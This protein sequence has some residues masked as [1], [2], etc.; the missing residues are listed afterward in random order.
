MPFARLVG[1]RAVLALL[2]RGVARDSLP[3]SLMFVGPEGVGKCTTAVA[4]AQLLNCEQVVGAGSDQPDACGRC[5]TC[6][7]IAAGTY[8]ELL[9]VVPG[10]NATIRIEAVRDVLERVPYRPFEGRRR[11]VIVDRA[12]T[13]QPGAQNALLKTLEEPNSSTVFVLVT[14]RP[15][16]MLDTVQSR[17]PR[18]RFGQLDANDVATV[19]MRDHRYNESDARA[20]AAASGGSPGRGLQQATEQ[21]EQSRARAEQVLSSLAKGVDFRRRLEAGRLLAEK[22]EGSAPKRSTIYGSER[23]LLSERLRALASLLR[24]LGVLVTRS[25]SRWLANAD[26]ARQLSTL[27][28]SFD[29]DRLVR[30]FSA[31][32]NARQALDR[33][34]SPKAVADWVAF[35]V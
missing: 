8:S 35:Q 32:D 25:D 14:A 12:D 10:E 18:L 29:A 16:S 1:H 28:P 7:R 21:F 6:K 22:G 23:A 11:V 26:R 34:V 15:D 20:R 13:L 27:V 19:L 31:V 24:D 17:C 2:A 3:P 30:A 9:V 33:N 4:L 5:A